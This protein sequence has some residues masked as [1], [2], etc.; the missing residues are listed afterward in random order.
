M[1]FSRMGLPL[2]WPNQRMS[3]EKLPM[4]NR[5]KVKTADIIDVETQEKKIAMPTT[6]AN[7]SK[8]KYTATSSEKS[9]SAKPSF[10]HCQRNVK[11][12]GHYGRVDKKCQQQPCIFSQ[13]EFCPA[14]G[15]RK[16][17]VN[18]ASFNLL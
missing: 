1:I 10:L 8:I 7:C 3:L 18:R 5:Q 9:L 14:D 13:D 17:I 2:S 6:M 12:H 16:N 4:T 15:F 11:T